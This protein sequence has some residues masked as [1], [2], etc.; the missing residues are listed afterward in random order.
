[1]SSGGKVA[2]R[3]S[4]TGTCVSYNFPADQYANAFVNCAIGG[5]GGTVDSKSTFRSAGTLLSRIR[6]PPSVPWPDGGPESLRLPCS[7]LAIYKIKLCS[8][9][10]SDHG[11]PQTNLLHTS[12]YLG[13]FG[14]VLTNHTLLRN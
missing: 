7:A 6:A 10:L 1:M 9:K 5:V 2:S 8:Y 3:K 14:S 4:R 11:Q 13:S 12:D